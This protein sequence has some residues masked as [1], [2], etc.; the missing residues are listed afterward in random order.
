MDK[1]HVSRT[2]GMYH[3][4][5]QPHKLMLGRIRD[6]PS[7]ESLCLLRRCFVKVFLARC[8][9]MIFHNKMIRSFQ[10]QIE[11]LPIP[12]NTPSVSKNKRTVISPALF[13]LSNIIDGARRKKM[14]RILVSLTA[15]CFRFSSFTSGLHHGR[16]PLPNLVPTCFLIHDI[17]PWARISKKK[18]AR[19]DR[20][21]ILCVEEYRQRRFCL[22]MTPMCGCSPLLL[23]QNQCKEYCHPVAA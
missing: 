17:V 6:H 4:R 5:T 23:L 21:A 9:T 20:D 19:T 7:N 16:C 11:L 13:V 12:R 15:G 10:Q 8:T 18:C 1:D 14:K 3:A 22:P 2:A